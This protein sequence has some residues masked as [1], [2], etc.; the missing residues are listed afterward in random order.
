MDICSSCTKTRG[1][2]ELKRCVPLKYI[3]LRK[4]TCVVYKKKSLTMHEECDDDLNQ[5]EQETYDDAY[6]GTDDEDEGDTLEMKQRKAQ[7]KQF[8]DQR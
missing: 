7:Q 8:E 3:R 4:S 1:S 2:D 5:E 6:P